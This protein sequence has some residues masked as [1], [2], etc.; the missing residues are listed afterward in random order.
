VTIGTVSKE[1]LLEKSKLDQHIYKKGHKVGWD[2][3]KILE[4][5]NNS[6]YRKCKELAH[7]ACLTNLIGQHG[8]DVSP[9]WIPLINNEITNSD[10][11][12]MIDS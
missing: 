2:E 5:E 9:I 3:A 1:G 6:K 10:Q 4:N 8:L 7:M 12:G 11:Y